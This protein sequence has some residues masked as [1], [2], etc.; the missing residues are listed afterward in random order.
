MSVPGPIKVYTVDLVTI[1]GVIY[2]ILLFNNEYIHMICSLL[3][4]NLFLS[5]T[6]VFSIVF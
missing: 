6:G 2:Y 3:K 4:V 1:E 5:V